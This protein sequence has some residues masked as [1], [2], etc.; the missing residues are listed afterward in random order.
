MDQ[1]D[2]RS[3]GLDLGIDDEGLDRSVT[4]LERDIFVMSRGH[5]KACFGPVLGDQWTGRKE[6]KCEE[7]EEGYAHGRSVISEPF[8]H[9]SMKVNAETMY[10]W[11]QA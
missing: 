8:T 4:V 6:N 1:N 10:E 11:R 5:F 3:F 9:K 7:F 2:Y